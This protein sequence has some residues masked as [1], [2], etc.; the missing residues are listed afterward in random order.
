MFCSKINVTTI[1]LH[2]H[3]VRI[4]NYIIFML[5]ILFK[6]S[7]YIKNAKKNTAGNSKLF[8]GCIALKRT[9]FCSHSYWI[10][11]LSLV[12]CKRKYEPK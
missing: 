9:Q 6:S 5:F 10:L 1:T 8:I 11:D 12:S 7:I 2:M 3:K 4:P